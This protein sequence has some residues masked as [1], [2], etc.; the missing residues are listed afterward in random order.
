MKVFKMFRWLVWDVIGDK[1]FWKLK[2]VLNGGY[3]GKAQLLFMYF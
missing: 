2:F 3:F 1:T